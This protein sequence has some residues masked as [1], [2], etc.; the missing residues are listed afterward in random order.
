[1][2]IWIT[3]IGMVSPLGSSS[4]DTMDALFAGK[5]GIGALTLFDM[6][7]CRSQLAAEAP[8]VEVCDDTW[9]RTD[10]MAAMAVREALS[11]AALDGHPADL[12]VGGTTAGMFETEA[13]LSEMHRQPEARKPLSRMLSHPLSATADRLMTIRPFGRARTIC[14]ACSSGA[15][16]LVLAAAWLATGKSERVVAGGADGLC[17]VTYAGFNALGAL[18][19]GPCRPFHAERDGL[20]L[21]EGAAFL[22]LETEAAARARGAE[23]IVE[24]R[25][26]GV[27][28]EAHHITHPEPSGETAARVM[29]QA[30]ARGRL[31]PEDIGYVNAHGTATKLND[32]MECAALRACFGPRITVSS[33]KAQ[34]GHTLGAAGALEAAITAW[35][36]W[37]GV[38]PPT[39]GL[40]RIDPSC[41]LDHVTE[42]RPLSTDAAMSN[43]FGF[44]GSDVVVVFSRPG[45]FPEIDAAAPRPVLVSASG[46]VG[47]LG[48]RDT[49]GAQGYLEPADA[50]VEGEIAF[51]AAAQLD[52]ARARRIDRAGR[53][54]AAAMAAALSTA[55]MS[56]DAR[57]RA[58]AIVGVAFGA[59]DD[60]AA[61]VHRIYDKGPRFASPAVFPN[62]LP[63]SP[64]AH[65]SIYHRLMGPVFSNADLG[66]TSES[67]MVTAAELIA[68]GEADAMFAGGVE[69]ASA[70]IAAVLSPLCSGEDMQHRSEG[71]AVLLLEAEDA[72][73]ARGARPVARIAWWSSWRGSVGAAL[74]TLPA[75]SQRAQVILARNDHPWR[76]VLAGTRWYDAPH[77]LVA[78]RAGDHE[79]AGGFAAAAAVAAIANGDLDQAL[80]LGLAPDRGYALLFTTPA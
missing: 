25:G 49:A 38:A 40:D 8:G 63:S 60:C 46:S 22:V 27:G 61:F 41:S 58:G 54:G 1:M 72:L 42:A 45:A 56:E 73:A 31:R 9:S 53:L 18:S 70:I 32:T 76:E 47:P 4:A 6:S 17:R 80:L 23:P 21:G 74:A 64:V 26:W 77:Q 66:A 51:D 78:P 15:N 3:G 33:S 30:L 43:S 71:S 69:T 35:S 34:I 14:S 79:G 59:V 55:A 10:A 62:L 50:S 52:L 68:A 12:I 5:S 67:A 7:G 75:P 16:A 39:I 24:L 13:M 57:H 19:A 2:R 28:A 29:R 65:A 37:R 44:G 48:V 20:T 36:L 11:R